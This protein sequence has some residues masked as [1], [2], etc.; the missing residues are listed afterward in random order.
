MASLNIPVSFS[1]NTVADATQVNQNFEEVE[2]YINTNLVNIDG[3]VKAPTTAIEDGAVTAAKLAANSVTSAKMPA[4]N[5]TL[6]Y[7]D[8]TL[9]GG[10]SLGGTS[11]DP[12][13][14]IDK[15]ISLTGGKTHQNVI[16]VTCL[17]GVNA[18]GLGANFSRLGTQ[19]VINTD[20][21]KI[22]VT[23]YISN[24][25]AGDVA[26]IRVWLSN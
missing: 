16:S 10:D 18:T 22:K 13:F 20:P 1:N 15:E 26:Y 23:A 25:V 12:R 7:Q 8:F 21:A 6:T 3:S 24:S 14:F 17:G 11:S 9:T 4:N 2:S 19:A 5:F